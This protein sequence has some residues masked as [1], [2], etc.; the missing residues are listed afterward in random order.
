MSARAALVGALAAL[1]V[2]VGIAIPY[3]V[4]S[5]SELSV[6]YGVGP[7]SPILLSVVAA[8]AFVALTGVARDATDPATATGAALVLG[9]ALFG[10][11]AWWAIEVAAVVGGLD[12]SAAFTYHRWA[13]LALAAIVPIATATHAR[14]I[15]RPQGP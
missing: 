8:V 10:L 11:L 9:L 1:G 4:L 15:L 2:V 13:L 5:A 14:R 7:V 3:A 6:Y 12:V